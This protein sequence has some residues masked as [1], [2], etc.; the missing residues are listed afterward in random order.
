MN[1]FSTEPGTAGF[2]S[3]NSIGGCGTGEVTLGHDRLKSLSAVRLWRFTL[4]RGHR[5]NGRAEILSERDKVAGE[6]DDKMTS[7]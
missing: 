1:S 4:P 2:D 7:D 3:P 6:D 5:E